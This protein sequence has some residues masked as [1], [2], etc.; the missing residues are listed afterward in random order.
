MGYVSIEC[1]FLSKA[2]KL[3]NLALTLKQDSQ[4]FLELMQGVVSNCNIL[5]LVDEIN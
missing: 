4:G 2:K 1:V 3:L 5:F